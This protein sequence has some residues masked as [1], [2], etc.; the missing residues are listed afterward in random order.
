MKC[1]I[2]IDMQW[3]FTSAQP[4]WLIGNVVYRIE[5]YMMN[6]DPIIIVQYTNDSDDLGETVSEITE[7]LKGY[8]KAW[9]VEKYDDDGGEVVDCKLREIEIYDKITEFEVIGVN[10]DCCV[11]ETAG[12]MG[13]DYSPIPIRVN[14]ECCNSPRDIEEAIDGFNEHIEWR[15]VNN[16]VSLV[17]EPDIHFV[18][19]QDEGFF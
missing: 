17:G 18:E 1:L 2:V 12:T 16:N 10:L 4:S 8:Q 11:A 6:M 3:F 15:E 5:Q 7:T 9:V 14:L 19:E 13:Y